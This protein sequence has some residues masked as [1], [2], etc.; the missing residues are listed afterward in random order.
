M[1]LIAA[2]YEVFVV[3]DAVSSRTEENKKIG[4]EMIREGQGKIT[5]VEAVL[6]ALLKRSTHEKFRE[7]ARLIK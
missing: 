4:L 5:S 6:F 3:A 2:G 1:D 7:I